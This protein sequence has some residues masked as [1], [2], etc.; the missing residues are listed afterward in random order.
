MTNK[1]TVGQRVRVISETYRGQ[2]GTVRSLNERGDKAVVRLDDL[3]SSLPFYVSE[4]EA[5]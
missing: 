1:L 5:V 2:L 3:G 4:L